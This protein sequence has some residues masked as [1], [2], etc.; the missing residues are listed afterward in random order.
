MQAKTHA[1]M[2]YIHKE[3]YAIASSL[4]VMNKKC[5]C[6][7]GMYIFLCTE[8]RLYCNHSRAKLLVLRKHVVRIVLY[9]APWYLRQDVHKPND[10]KKKYDLTYVISNSTSHQSLSTNAIET[11]GLR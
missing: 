11:Y 1:K 3:W 8:G 5:V 10:K 4:F 2:L 7:G 9:V 6:G